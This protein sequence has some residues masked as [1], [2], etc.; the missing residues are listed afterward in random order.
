MANR[1]TNS[2]TCHPITDS[3]HIFFVGIG[4]SGMN[5]L[6]KFLL[7]R[8]YQVS[9]SDR[10][11]DRAQRPE[12]YASLQ[13]RG[14]LLFPQ[15][16][17]GISSVLD[18]VVFSTAVEP[19][20]PDIQVAMTKRIPRVHRSEELARQL[21][22]YRSIAVSGTSGKTTVTAMLAW[23]FSKTNLDPTVLVG[24][25]IP[26]LIDSGETDFLAGS[27]DLAIFEADES[28]G[29]LIRFTPETGLI[30]NI[31]KD[32]KE[33]TELRTIFTTFGRQVQQNLILNA[34]SPDVMS[35]NIVGRNTMT[36]G[37]QKPCDLRGEEWIS[38]G[39][40]SQFKVGG[41]QL[42]VPLPGYHNAENA[43]AACAVAQM[44]GVELER[45]AESIRTFPGVR[46]RFERIGTKHDV[47][48]VDDYAHNPDKIRA[49]L[50]A[51]HRLSK[52]VIVVYQPHGFG[53]TRFLKKD[54]IETFQSH[55]TSHDTLFIAPIYYAGGTVAKDIDSL[56]L[57]CEIRKANRSAEMVPRNHI[58]Q[59]TALVAEPG[60]L[61][62][63]MGARDPSLSELSREIY[64]AL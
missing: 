37:F 48:V 5:T 31:S 21:R 30:H 15:N 50:S 55:L 8:G 27:S 38:D 11:F 12:F 60:D 25:P 6:A 57:V 46:R 64:S 56:D 19:S 54:L 9:G 2:K 23:I 17:T 42:F 63:I 39:W 14:I 43:L 53:P 10:E 13:N 36:Y 41:Q 1:N 35:L 34:D 4:G 61:I 40:G 45:F 33:M 32:H 24:A 20:I 51:S 16:G 26:D 44:Y 3:K 52:R 58:A 59:K 18:R 62:L 47:T 7:H 49:A 29:S 22:N 28:D